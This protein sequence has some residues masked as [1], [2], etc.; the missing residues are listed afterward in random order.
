[1][2]IWISAVVLAMTVTGCGSSPPPQGDEEKGREKDQ[3]PRQETVFDDMIQTEDKA[4]QAGAQA[5]NRVNDLNRQLQAQEG[6]DA[7]ASDAKNGNE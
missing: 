6:G 4:R 5:E 2:R 7:A 1:M 3:A